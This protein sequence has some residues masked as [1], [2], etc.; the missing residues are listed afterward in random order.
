[1]EPNDV[2]TYLRH[3]CTRILSEVGDKTISGE[4]Y[5]TMLK[6][7]T[8]EVFSN[9]RMEHVVHWVL[10]ESGLTYAAAYRDEYIGSKDNA[11]DS[12][13]NQRK[14]IVDKSRVSMSA[15]GKLDENL[16][17]AIEKYLKIAIARVGNE[18]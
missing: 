15:N 12:K 6:Q 9:G 17:R 13:N 18:H 2:K 7:Y 4:E 1:M 3:V 8:T 16:N 11:D 5:N 14:E 10:M